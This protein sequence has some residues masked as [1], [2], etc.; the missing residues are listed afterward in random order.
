MR[1]LVSL[2]IKEEEEII[3]KGETSS[4]APMKT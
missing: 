3:K 2:A 1:K 4:S